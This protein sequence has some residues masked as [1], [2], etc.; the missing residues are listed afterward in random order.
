M[1]V[2]AR[3]A[4]RAVAKLEQD[5]VALGVSRARVSVLRAVDLHH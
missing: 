4:Q 3:E 2:L 5:A 1:H